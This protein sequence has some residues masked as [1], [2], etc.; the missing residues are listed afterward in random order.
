MSVDPHAL[1]QER[2]PQEKVASRLVGTQDHESLEADRVVLGRQTR[3]DAALVRSEGAVFGMAVMRTS[4]SCGTEEHAS[5]LVAVTEQLRLLHVADSL[6]ANKAPGQNDPG[7]WRLSERSPL[8]QRVD[9]FFNSPRLPISLAN[10]LT[11][12]IVVT[13]S[14]EQLALSAKQDIVCPRRSYV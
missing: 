13:P 1:H 5:I 10:I 6:T 2:L 11:F 9:R 7:F 12:R 8:A 14:Q 4:R 3:V